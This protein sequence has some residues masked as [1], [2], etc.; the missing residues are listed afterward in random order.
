[1]KSK[2]KNVLLL[3]SLLLT[4]AANA[5]SMAEQILPMLK[6]RGSN[7]DRQTEPWTGTWI[8]VP[9]INPQ[10]YSVTYFRKEITLAQ[11]PEQ[12]II[13]V[14]GDNRYKLYVNGSLV[15]VGPA[16]GA[17]QSRTG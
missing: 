15:S 3:S 11:K 5:Q 12:F 13:H 7:Y 9:G 6:A 4:G 10:D 16:R 1:M 17:D 14:T 8:T 2:L